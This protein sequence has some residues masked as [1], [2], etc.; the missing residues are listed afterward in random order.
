MIPIGQKIKEARKEK[1]MTQEELA[2]SNISR[3]LISLIENGLSYPSMQTL[4]Y[5]STKLDK[6]ISYF[7]VENDT[8]SINLITDLEYLLDTEEYVQIINNS[9]NFIKY[10]L[11]NLKNIKNQYLG[12]LYCILG[13]AYYK[14]NNKLTYEYLINSVDYLKSEGNNKYISK[15]YNYLSLVMYRN[16]NYE[17]MEHYLN[18][19]DSCFNIVTYENVNQKLNILYNLSLAY[20]YQRKYSLTADILQEAL[21]HS[22]KHELYYNFGEFN[23]LL[24]LSYKNM[25]KLDNAIDCSMKAIKYYKLTENKYMEHRCYINLSILFRVCS[26][27]YNSL[28]YINDAIIY[29]Q[30]IGDEVKLINAKV[31]K[32]IT[33]F[34]L[35]EEEDLTLEMVDSIIRNPNCNDVAR[36]ELLTITA[37]L[38]LN[39]KDYSGLLSMFNTAE[40]L[41]FNNGDSEMFIFIY[42]GL[43]TIYEQLNDDKNAE[44][45]KAKLDKLLKDQPYFEKFLY[46]K[47]NI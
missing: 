8:D 3:S 26:D 12:I 34:I 14:T 9:E 15:A 42:Q 46:T 31:E 20:Y 5:L 39:N 30:S 37:S 13:I 36:G 24:A 21:L 38:K 32:I 17:Q 28:N 25:D 47:D 40:N 27:Y 44:V 23:M 10:K 33:M 41:I 22:K 11:S 7:L 43:F 6:H 4:E 16:K 29:F 35:K 19:S 18:L 2:D 45:Y 1:K